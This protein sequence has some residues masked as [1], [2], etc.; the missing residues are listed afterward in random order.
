MN[1]VIKRT[2]I[3]YVFIIALISANMQYINELWLK[4]INLL[5][6]IVCSHMYWKLYQEVKRLKYD[7][8]DTDY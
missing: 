8:D 5:A 6:F 1:E 4:T 2:M 3:F 7:T